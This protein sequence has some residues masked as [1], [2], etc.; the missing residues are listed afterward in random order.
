MEISRNNA[1]NMTIQ[2]R[3]QLHMLVY[4]IVS[5]RMAYG[6]YEDSTSIRS[7]LEAEIQNRIRRLKE[8]ED[9]SELEVAQTLLD[10]YLEKFQARSTNLT[11][12]PKHAQSPTQN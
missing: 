12:E 4:K 5:L 1:I 6:N 10:L 8:I 9:K 3:M 11:I 2:L 7:K